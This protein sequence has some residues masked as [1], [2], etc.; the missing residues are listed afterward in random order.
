MRIQ[1]RQLA[2]DDALELSHMGQVWVYPWR[3]KGKAA[4]DTDPL[5]AR[6]WEI[7]PRD[8]QRFKPPPLKGANTMLFLTEQAA[9]A[10]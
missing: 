8:S 10:G 1:R 7:H 3:E 6:A 9:V 4:S 5:A 2:R